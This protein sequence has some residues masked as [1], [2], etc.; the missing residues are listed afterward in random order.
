M[1]YCYYTCLD[2]LKR[3]LYIN[4]EIRIKYTLK[5]GTRPA[6]KRRFKWDFHSSN[7]GILYE[8]GLV[9][10]LQQDTEHFPEIVQ[11]A[12]SHIPHGKINVWP[13]YIVPK[14]EK[15]ASEKRR[16]IILGD[17][18][19]AIPP[20]SGQGINQALEDAY[21]LALLLAQANKIN[22]QDALNFWQDYRQRRVEKVLSLGNQI[23]LRRMSKE[24]RDKIPSKSIQKIEL[25]WLF[26]PDFKG[27]VDR[28]VA[29]RV[30]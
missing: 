24:E 3:A 6:E 14:L 4:E 22:M 19:H 1:F 28:W 30:E 5:P 2:W 23:E 18:A 10:F 11:N 7:H 13:F 29:A 25:S 21:I 16:V 20:S 12:V 27:D 8:E 26:K 15:W 9:K 17:G